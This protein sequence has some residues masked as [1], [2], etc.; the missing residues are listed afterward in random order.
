MT[1]QTSEEQQLSEPEPEKV[2]HDNV[3][4][5][6]EQEN[7]ASHDIMME[8]E[9]QNQNDIEISEPQRYNLR[10]NRERS[11]SH[12]FSFLS[13][14]AGLNKWVTRQRKQFETSY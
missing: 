6:E 11:Y 12:K 5:Q 4:D 9:L 8:T 1:E 2:G 14:K 10:P 3:N 7:N 13:V